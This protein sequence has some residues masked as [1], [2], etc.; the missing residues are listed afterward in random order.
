MVDANIHLRLLHT[1]ILDM[2]KVF[3]LLLCCLKAICL[4]PHTA[5]LVNLA[6][7]LV[8]QGHLWNENNAITSW[9][10]LIWCVTFLAG[11]KRYKSTINL[12]FT[13]PATIIFTKF[14]P[15]KFNNYLRYATVPLFT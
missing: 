4:H 7:D 5:T 9:L 14:V 12:C 13:M 1:S 10:R 3:E 15:N 8:S 2:Y 6:P 11:T